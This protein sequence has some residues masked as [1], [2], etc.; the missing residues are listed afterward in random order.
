VA[1]QER[2]YVSKGSIALLTR[3]QPTALKP[4][5]DE[6]SEVIDQAARRTA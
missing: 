6:S 1:S 5:R 2:R 3:P 4:R